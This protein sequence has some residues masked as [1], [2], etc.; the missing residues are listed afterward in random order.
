[1]AQAI[2]VVVTETYT[3]TPDLTEEY[4]TAEG[5]STIADALRADREAVEAG[6]FAI[7]EIAGTA[8]V[9]TYE[10]SIVDE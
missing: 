7:D 9:T 5:F 2:R 4:Y 1:M 3:Y 10:W 6:D 8:S